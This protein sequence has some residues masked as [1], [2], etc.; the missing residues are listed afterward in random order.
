MNQGHHLLLVAD[1]LGRVIFQGL[2]YYFRLVMLRG[3]KQPIHLYERRIYSQN[4]EDG[5]IGY[6]FHKIGVTDKYFVEI[7]A[8]DGKQCNTRFL[9]R[10]GWSG[11]Q[12]DA[13]KSPGIKQA[14]VDAGNVEALFKRYKVPE[15]FDLLS[16]DID[17]NDY[18]IWKAIAVYEPRVVVIEYN[19]VVGARLSRV[20]P[21]NKHH[22]WDGTDYFGA[23]LA[24]LD[25]LSRK[26][27]YRLVGTDTMGINA[28][29]VKAESAEQYFT[30]SSVRELYHSP[31]YLIYPRSNRR[32][33]KV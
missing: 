17:G 26:K 8:G 28:F 33:A 7:G 24:A 4:G 10:Q 6:I 5:I 32:M 21:Y 16:I 29:F 9:K 12:I 11:I 13:E 23:S 3:Q 27:G 19:A 20:M 14:F 18:W 30:H 1:T 15:V 2:R 22:R 31:R 25:G